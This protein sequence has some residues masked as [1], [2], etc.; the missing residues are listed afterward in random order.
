MSEVVFRC[1]LAPQAR[2]W[3]QALLAL[4]CLFWL[5]VSAYLPWAALGFVG[6][7][8]YFSRL[9]RMPRAILVDVSLSE[10]HL[11]VRMAGEDDWVPLRDPLRIW[12]AWLVA[13]AP[14]NLVPFGILYLSESMLGEDLYRRVRRI[15]RNP[16]R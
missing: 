8:V 15:A 4:S 6:L 12:G 2:R 5:V 16:S 14:S 11:D 7:A 13:P 10:R 3:G 9:E 1:D